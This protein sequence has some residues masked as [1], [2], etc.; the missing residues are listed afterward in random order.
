M[1][2]PLVSFTL[3]WL[4]GYTAALSLELSWLSLYVSIA[5]SIAAIIWW[6]AQG[7]QRILVCAIL[8]VGISAGY[9]ESYDRGNV[10]KLSFQGS[11]EGG[12]E[13]SGEGSFGAT[14]KLEG[15]IVS[16][17]VVD[18]D[19]ASFTLMVKRLLKE[20]G[21]NGDTASPT[22]NEPVAITVKLLTREEQQSAYSWRRADQVMMNGIA[23]APQVARNYDGFDYRAYLRLQ[24]IHWTVAVKGIASLQFSSPERWTWQSVLRWNDQFRALLGQ[25]IDDIFPAQQGGF[26]KSMLIGLTDDMDPLQFQQFSQLGLTHILA[27]S[28]LNVAVF[29]G[30]LLWLL[31][32]FRCTR[33]TC[34]LTAIALMPLYIALTGGSPSIVRA[35]LMAMIALYAAYR[36]T[37]KDGLHTVLL[38]GLLMLLWE[39]YY[40]MDVSFQLSFL[41]T[42]G[43]IIGVPPVNKLLPV[44]SQMLKSSLS[45]ALVAQFISFPVSIYYFNQLSLL[46]LAANLCLV[47]VFSMVTMPIGT[48]ALVMGFI[49]LPAGQA[50]AWL[51]AQINEWVFVVVSFS[52][53]WDFFQT[54]WA[55]P[56][57]GWMVSYYTVLVIIVWSL[58]RLQHEQASVEEPMLIAKPSLKFKVNSNGTWGSLNKTMKW[59]LP[60]AC[61]SLLALL[62]Y[63]YNPD[64]WNETGEGHIHFI[65]V[66]QGDSILIRS[67]ISRS[68]TLI[69]G[70]GTISFFKPGEEWKLRKDPYEVGRKLLVPLLKKRGIQQIDYLII[71]HEDADHIGGLQAL[72]EQIPVRQ[73]IFNGTL[74]PGASVEK[75]FKTALDKQ[76]QLV[77]VSSGDS[78][79]VDTL[80]ELAVLY[81][82]S[83]ATAKGEIQI[84]KEQ[85]GQSVVLMMRMAD[86]KWLFTGDIDQASEAA[87]VRLTTGQ[88]SRQGA[89]NEGADN[90]G[91]DNEGVTGFPELSLPDLMKQG[92]I[93]VLKVAH[94]GSKTSTS[95]S[96]LQAFQP[97]LAVISAGANNVYGHPHP[98][99]ME[100]LQQHDIQVKRTDTMGE[101]QMLVRNGQITV[102]T[103]LE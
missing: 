61:L 96:W 52:S 68:I 10:S 5:L 95:S 100:R 84:E 97:K 79:Q 15:V 18:G 62:V 48:A 73:L 36:H 13:G 93:D 12:G 32:K 31:R 58:L 74:K 50:I 2:R 23:K 6:S 87:I 55:S 39:P 69:D 66:G 54:I 22:V 35:G 88:V 77:K 65:D 92:T 53:R 29:L 72:L 64:R 49:Y 91:A 42:I 71:S 85:N 8:L 20:S 45:I 80:T 24:H 27:V 70:G 26:M 25:R 14:V 40:L 99:V 81:P 47:P 76:V 59:L 3:L 46:S 67:P 51:V 16:R 57:I 37:L 90:E 43:L 89:D 9:Y 19:K 60:T 75:L 7:P 86:T 94:H 44:R 21:I 41:V 28:G 63:A 98:L 82:F 34:L 78:L 38:V 101:V 1:N 83:S 17:V 33:E 4:G 30:C 102:Q 103:K 56:S 11:G